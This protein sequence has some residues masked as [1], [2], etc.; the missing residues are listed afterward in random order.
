MDFLSILSDFNIEE[1]IIAVYGSIKVAQSQCYVTKVATEIKKE[2]EHLL[3]YS[4]N[5]SG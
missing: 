1:T 2:Q 5:F 4:R 3:S